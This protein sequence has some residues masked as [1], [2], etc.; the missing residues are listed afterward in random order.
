MVLLRWNAGRCAAV[1]AAWGAAIL[2]V[3]APP[4]VAA[5]Q[6][7]P[8]RVITVTSIAE[9]QSAADDAQ[10]GDRIEL[11]DGVYTT[12]GPITL[13]RSGTPDAPVTVAA[14]QVGG[15]ELRGAAGF[16]FAGADH[17][18]VEGFRLTHSGG[19]NISADSDHVR[20][21][22]N[23]V[24]ISGSATNWVTVTGDDAEV[25]HNTFQ[26][27]STHGVF[28]QISGPG[29][30]DMAQRS[31]VHHN[32]F[33]NHSFAGDNGG[34]SIRLGYSFRQLGSAKAIIEH[35][36]FERADGDSEA[37][38]VKSA[39]NIVRFNTIRDSRGS[40]VLR[41]GNR[42]LV[43][44]NLM[45]GGSSGLRFYDND[46]VLINNLIQGG[47]GQIIAGQG[48]IVDD[49]TG[50]TAHARPDR[51]LVAFNTIVGD[52]TNLLDVG[53]G[54]KEFGPNECTFANNILVGGGSGDLANIGKATDL[55]W[56]GNIVW[57]GTG[58]NL[59]SSGYRVVDPAL[60]TDDG[61]LHRLAAGSPAIDSAAGS[62]PQVGQ[63]FDP[64]DRSG[65][66]DVGADEHATGGPQRRPLTTADVGPN[67][68]RTPAT[69]GE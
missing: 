3:A 41:H 47:S 55:R 2:T 31:H 12:S 17:L 54:S 27:K 8:A 52:R 1:A 6:A 34:E 61:G 36:L 58:G 21:T 25:D 22:R 46:H 30:S 50:S 23:V 9:L 60:V 48:T 53:S 57:A 5:P 26:N 20:F 10:P 62:Y 42:N 63:D 28:L 16:S 19:M 68:P 64:Q 15:A 11:V 7:A 32:Y 69:P 18:I 40:I 33:F 56:E 37:I 65:A 45:L 35:N 38:S 67:A 66:K 39:D 13:R 59:P 43:E 44:S 51:V 4:A 14:Q 49:T 24:Q 29:E